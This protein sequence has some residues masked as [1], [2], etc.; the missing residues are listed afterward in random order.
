MPYTIPGRVE[1]YYPFPHDPTPDCNVREPDEAS[2]PP[3]LI[4]GDKP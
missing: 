1:V 2:P 4:E 3:A